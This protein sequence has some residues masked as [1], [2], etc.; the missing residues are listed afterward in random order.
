VID[1]AKGNHRPAQKSSYVPPGTIDTKIIC[2]EANKGNTAKCFRTDPGQIIYSS[3]IKSVGDQKVQQKCAC[4][5]GRSTPLASHVCRCVFLELFGKQEKGGTREA[6]QKIIDG[7]RPV[8]H[9]PSRRA[10]PN[11]GEQAGERCVQNRSWRNGTV[12]MSRAGICTEQQNIL[13]A[14]RKQGI[15]FGG[16][17]MLP[18]LLLLVAVVGRHTMRGGRRLISASLIPNA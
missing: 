9:H 16:V 2:K 6:T 5:G 13:A 1:G 14:L 15:A 17:A 4:E 18:L 10:W 3:R 12:R 11:A 8:H 7:S